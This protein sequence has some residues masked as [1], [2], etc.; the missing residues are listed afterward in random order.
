MNKLEIK[1]NKKLVLKK[2]LKKR[3]R[4]IQIEKLDVEINRFDQQLKLLKVQTYGP[5]VTRNCGTLIHDDGSVSMDYELYVQ[6]EDY[7]QYQKYFIVVD[8]IIVDNCLYLRFNDSAEYIPYAFS[9]LDIYIY[10]NDIP[11]KNDVYTVYLNGDGEKVIV[12]IFRPVN[13]L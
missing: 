3:L 4:G 6:A 2:V 1:R 13:S 8:E 12:D 10:E 11:I 9:K 5:L 7:Q